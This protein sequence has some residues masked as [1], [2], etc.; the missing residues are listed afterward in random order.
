[1]ETYESI[2]KQFV[3][4]TI[5]SK[6][7][8]DEEIIT[9]KDTEPMVTSVTASLTT[10]ESDRFF[11]NHAIDLSYFKERHDNRIKITLNME[12]IWK[13]QSYA[14]QTR[15]I[16][17][18]GLQL[19]L[20]MPIDISV[21]EIVC[22]N[23]APLADHQLDQP[24]LNY[25]VIRVRQ[26]LHDTL[27]ALQCVDNDTKDGLLVI[28]DL[29]ATSSQAAFA[30]LCDPE[31]A[32]LTAQALL[33]ERFYMRSTSI[34]P[35]FMFECQED[36]SPLRIIFS[37][38]VN[39]RHLEAFGNSQGIYDLGSLV[40]PKRIKLLTRLALRD[41]KAETL[42]AVYRSHEHNEPQVI[43]D[44]E[45]KN[46]KHWRRLLMR[47]ADQPEFRVF[48]AVARLA[49]HPVK[50]RL[51]HALEPLNDTGEKYVRKLLKVAK[52]LSVVGALIDVTEQIRNWIQGGCS[53]DH[54]TYENPIICCEKEQPLAPPQLI[55]VHYIQ[56]N[57]CEDRFL[58]RMQVEV[59]IAG[60]LFPGVTRDVSAHGLSVKIE[61]L[62]TASFDE[63]QATISF[64]KLD[65]QSS[66]LARFQGIFR[67][68]PAVVV[69]KHT[70]REKLLRFKISDDAKGHQFSKAFLAFL[71]K[72]QSDLSL[73]NSHLFRAATS[74]LYSPIFIESSSTLPIF[75]YQNHRND[76][77]YRFGKTTYPT[78]LID[79]LE[80]ADGKYDFNF[81]S[82]CG[83]LTRIIQQLSVSGSSELTLYLCKERHYNTPSFVIRSLADFEISDEATQHK[84]VQHAMDHDF[85]CVKVIVTQPKAPPQA[86]IDQVINRLTQLSPSKSERLKDEFGS[87]VAIGDVVDITG[88]VTESWSEELVDISTVE[89]STTE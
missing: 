69:G 30:D 26:L 87:L 78:P 63:C 51:E 19:R 9:E 12:V 31:D 32:L 74:R 70:D 6:Q 75:I 53:L 7:V 73:D 35:F 36:N 25:R 3:G 54:N 72:H 58:G 24:L 80:V 38:Q 55:P 62:D 52:S 79:F 11:N 56:E 10:L 34:L 29:I 43:A 23:V 5:N 71:A 57:R 47:S 40:T 84:F 8:A 86:E 22:I 33:A 1:M 20:K 66:S 17:N 37:N 45:C 15:D 49:H 16:S 4:E 42:I 67:N 21:N 13:E 14:A 44:L 18:S 65:S 59:S 41:S 82:D 50:M 48:K 81:L 64:P 85:R 28:S 27:L 2:L 68:V 83:R 88:L 61:S 76:W 89:V 39:R 77:T 60:R 46:H